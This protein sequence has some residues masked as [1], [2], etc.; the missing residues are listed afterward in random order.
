MEDVHDKLAYCL[1]V[2]YLTRASFDCLL[3]SDGNHVSCSLLGPKACHGIGVAGG[4]A[5]ARPIIS[6]EEVTQFYYVLATSL[7]MGVVT[8]TH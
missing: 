2:Q 7:C 6:A 4:L 5:V 3:S 8:Q 1:V